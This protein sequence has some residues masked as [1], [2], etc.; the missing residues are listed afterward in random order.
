MA[1][2]YLVDAA[3]ASACT[4]R[5]MALRIVQHHEVEQIMLRQTEMLRASIAAAIAAATRQA[6]LI[7]LRQRLMSELAPE[8]N[9]AFKPE[10][11]TPSQLAA[12]PDAKEVQQE[13]FRLSV[14]L[15]EKINDLRRPY[16]SQ[17]L[18]DDV[19][20]KHK[21]RIAQA[22]MS[23]G[24]VLP[25]GLDGTVLVSHA[26]ARGQT[27]MDAAREVLT[28]MDE[29]ARV[30]LDTEQLKDAWSVRIAGAQSFKDIDDLGRAI[31]RLQ[32]PPHPTT[33]TNAMEGKS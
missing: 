19:V 4:I 25:G 13:Q 28:E 10:H 12:K 27:L 21:G 2:G 9:Q 29:T 17:Y 23:S 33:P 16:V 26:A 30:L 5:D 32:L 11:T 22:V 8:S 7:A 15:R 24:G 20:L 1:D 18:L 31:S 3:A 6:E 14:Q